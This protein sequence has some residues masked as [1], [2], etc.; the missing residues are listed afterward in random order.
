MADQKPPRTATDALGTLTALLAFQRGSLLRNVE[1]LTS[2][3]AAAVSTAY[4]TAWYS[5][6]NLAR[7][8]PGDRVLIHSA[9]GGVGQAAIAIA[10]S[11]R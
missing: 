2:E 4:A 7:I 11:V 1:G 5:L 3:E 6:H 10:R 8:K 9:T